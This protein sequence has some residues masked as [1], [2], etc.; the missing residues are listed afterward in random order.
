M[1]TN[2]DINMT[3]DNNTFKRTTWQNKHNI[4]TL[5]V[6]ISYLL[7]IYYKR[8]C[9]KNSILLKGNTQMFAFRFLE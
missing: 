4:C 9:T 8:V 6:F 3:C 1:K 7:T 2:R 5:L